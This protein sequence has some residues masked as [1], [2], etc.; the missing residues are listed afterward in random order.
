MEKLTVN[1][2]SR[3]YDIL[4]GSDILDDLGTALLQRNILDIR[5][6]VAVLTSP[7]IGA[8]YF[9]SVRLS[10]EKQG[11]KDVERYDIPD[12]EEHKCICQYGETLDWLSNLPGARNMTPLVITLGGGV[13]GDLG[14][15][16]AHTF[17]RGVPFVQVTTTLLGVV[18][19]SVGGKVAVN[20]PAGKNLV[21][22]FHQPSMVMAD[23]D[24]LNTLPMSEIRSGMAEAIKYGAALDLGLF[25]LIEKNIKQLLRLEKKSLAKVARKCCEIKADVVARDELDDKG[26]RVSLNFGH[27]VGHAIEN[28]CGYAFTHGECVA[29]GMAAA[30]RLSVR[31]RLCQWKV[32]ERLENLLIAAG[33][34]VDCRDE[35]LGAN[36]IL[37]VMQ[38]D[39][40]W[41]GGKNRFVL[42]T[43]LGSWKTVEGVDMGTV[44]QVVKEVVG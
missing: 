39:K 31:L 3:V 20:L 6:P 16:V 28:A 40:K 10:L 34:P 37:R 12:G 17:K 15:F 21:G 8:H 38:Q 22:A 26:L 29:I 14:G 24:C 5:R 23:M 43:G 35:K 41:I 4:I 42:L 9:D 25:E 1:A 2:P 13:V 18:D 33:L 32:V 36:T 44:R 7:R 19:C 11:V 27:T 30:A